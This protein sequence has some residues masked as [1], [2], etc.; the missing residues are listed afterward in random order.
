MRRKLAYIL[1]N[2]GILVAVGA[3]IGQ[4]IVAMDADVNY[5]AGEEMVFRLSK[6]ESTYKGLFEADYLGSNADTANSTIID[7]VAEEM[8]DRLATWGVDATVSKE[9]YD[10]IRVKLRAENDD[11][12][13][14]TYLQNYLSHSGGNV[15]VAAGSDD[16]SVQNDAPTGSEYDDNAMFEGQTASIEYIDDSVPVVTIPVN[17]DGESGKLGELIKYCTENTVEENTSEGQESSA[18][19]CYLV[20]WSNMQ[21]GDSYIAATSSDADIK[22]SNM[23]KR[24]IFGENASNAW[25]V[26]ESDEDNNYKKLQLVPNSDAIKDGAYDASK[27]GS[28]YKA[29]FYYMN[30]LNASSYS[31]DFGCDVTFVYRHRATASVDDLVEA[32]AWHLSPAFGP[33]LIA[34]I[35]SLAALALV[36]ALLYRMGSLAILSNVAIALL[37]GAGLFAYF[38][39]AF[40][41]G[42]AVGFLLG[43]LVTA[44]GSIYYFAKFKEQLYA[45]RSTKKAHQEAI[46]KALWPTLDAGIAAILT[47]LCVYGLIPS[48]VGALGLSLILTSAFGLAANLLLLRIEGYLL[49]YDRDSDEKAGKLY[50][51]DMSRVPNALKEEKQTYFGPYANVKFAKAKWP[52]A[53]VLGAL[54]GVAAVGISVWSALGSPLNYSGAYEDTTSI[55]LEYRVEQGSDSPWTS[56]D[57]IETSFL[58]LIEYDGKT[59]VEYVS[60]DAI[61]VE[62]S[63][64]YDTQDI[65]EAYDV[66]NFGIDLDIHF[67]PDGVYTLTFQ[68]DAGWVTEETTLDDAVKQVGESLEMYSASANNVVVQAGTP[69]LG[70][71]Y[72]SL[73]IGALT[74]LAYSFFRYRPSRAIAGALLPIGAATIVTGFYSVTRLAVTPVSA[75]ASIVSFL[76]A[77]LFVSFLWN[78]EKEIRLDSRERDKDSPVFRDAALERATGEAAG[79]LVGY[80]ILCFG[81]LLAFLAFAPSAYRPIFLGSLIGVILLLAMTLAALAPLA[82]R[83]GKWLRAIKASVSNSLKKPA[84]GKPQTGNLPSGKRRAEPE[85][86]I[87]IGIND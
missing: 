70:T 36:S 63:V 53:G 64:A 68:T 8:E 40:G 9:G 43:A 72:L 65:E 46:K 38:H 85:E 4:T 32:G 14:Y 45:G 59:L 58:P 34:G 77:F 10:L 29:A 69:S 48:V 51:I 22:D 15:T 11:E 75:I 39:A 57:D 76:L 35:V 27:S 2:A 83:L 41:I 79:D 17:Y 55:S 71:V 33:T 5:A 3:T 61:Y 12:T 60:D 81:A 54:L 13:E 16:E 82:L 73:G 30:L 23:A 50:G 37:G 67:D 25:Y 42:A 24:L 74:L 7:E 84:S 18:K 78:K 1:L 47:G 20:L 86:A 26:D 6:P 28:A 19:N 49:A 80:A 56:T 87:F 44:F 31:E 21:E 62:T 66:Y 52:V